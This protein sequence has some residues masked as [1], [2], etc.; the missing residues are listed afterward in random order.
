M[1]ILAV[2]GRKFDTICI[3]PIHHHPPLRHSYHLLYIGNSV[4]IH[5]LSIFH[6]NNLSVRALM[7]ILNKIHTKT[8]SHISIKPL[9]A[10]LYIKSSITHSI[11]EAI[12]IAS[13]FINNF[14]KWR[15]LSTSVKPRLNQ[16]SSYLFLVNSDY[17]LSHFYLLDEKIFIR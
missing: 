15:S 10:L 13:S 8:N 11:L 14:L 9:A 2:H 4:L 3:L 16:S 1:R 12:L 17:T 7:K 5:I 6:A